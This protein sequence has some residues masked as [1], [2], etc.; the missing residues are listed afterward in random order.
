MNKQ[1]S[2]RIAAY[3]PEARTLIRFLI[4]AE[5]WSVANRLGMTNKQARENVE[6]RILDF[7]ADAEGKLPR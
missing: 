4:E 1:L 3:P 7:L 6:Q 2:A 5:T